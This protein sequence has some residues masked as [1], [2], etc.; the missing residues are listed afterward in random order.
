MIPFIPADRDLPTEAT[1]DA[2][3]GQGRITD[4][5]V[6]KKKE[7]VEIEGQISFDDDL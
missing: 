4:T 7:I 2:A 1:T 6:P 5:T 3:E